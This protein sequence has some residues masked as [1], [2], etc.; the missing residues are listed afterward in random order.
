MESVMVNAIM[1]LPVTE[2][3]QAAEARRRC[4]DLALSLGFSQT[5]AG[6]VA[7]IASE[8]AAN[9]YEHA[10]GGELLVSAA[11]D[12][13]IEILSVDHGPG[14]DLKRCM[15]DGYS[16]AGTAGT[17]L[18]AIRRLSAAFDAWSE[19]SG[20]V[21]VSRIEKQV[22]PQRAVLTGAARAPFPGETVCGDNYGIRDFGSMIAILL[23]DGLGHGAF[24]AEAADEAVQAFQNL[25]RRGAAET[26]DELHRAL[27]GT[28]GAALA[29]ALLD[30]ERRVITYS[31]L[32]NTSGVI[33]T[34]SGAKS[35][36]SHNGTAGHAA[37]R[38][39]EFRYPWPEGAAVIMHTDGLATS[40]SLSRY[41]GLTDRHPAV[42]SGVL[43]R[44]HARGRDDVAVVTAIEVQR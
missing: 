30:T 6:E 4:S 36:I 34:D 2:R 22:R 21:L 38:I 5:R 16:T 11:S 31:G 26:V 43:Y 28:R 25:D 32:G 23:V 10:Q 8:A 19:S 15:V 41:P 33:Q 17:G 27:R 1:R 29:V 39:S 12:S 13:A 35:M 24:A 44:D 40:W 3:S 7:I 9:L 14:M 18:G 42:I 20:T 37:Y